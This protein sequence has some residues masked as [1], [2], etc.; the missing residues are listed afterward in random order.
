MNAPMA[1]DTAVEKGK[2]AS[3]VERETERMRG[4]TPEMENHT[5]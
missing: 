5:I 4:A 1:A 2:A 3:E